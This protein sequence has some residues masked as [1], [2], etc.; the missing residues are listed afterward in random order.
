MCD[1]SFA[2]NALVADHEQLR[3]SRFFSSVCDILH[4]LPYPLP[5][6]E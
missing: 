2:A 6:T 3:H 5:E 4:D 1:K